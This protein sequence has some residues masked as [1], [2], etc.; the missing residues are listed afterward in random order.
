MFNLTATVMTGRENWN[1]K[2]KHYTRPNY[3]LNLGSNTRLRKGVKDRRAYLARENRQVGN[4][5]TKRSR[6]E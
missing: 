3:H 2:A 6:E 1:S 5:Q 4:N